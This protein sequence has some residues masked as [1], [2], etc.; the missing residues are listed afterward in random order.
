MTARQALLATLVA[1]AGCAPD[2]TE[3]LLVV[4]SDLA[5]PQELD[6][7]SVE[8]SSD[9]GGAPWSQDYAL[10]PNGPTTLPLSIGLVPESD[11][12]RAFRVVVT[13]LAGGQRRVQR[14]ATL[15]FAPRET[16]ILYLDLLAACLDRL[17]P[18]NRTCL[19][20]GGPCQSDGIST[21]A[22]PRI[23]P[24]RPEDEPLAASPRADGSLVSSQDA[25]AIDTA[26]LPV[27][28]A[29]PMDSGTAD[30]FRV[31][32]P[33]ERDAPAEA[34]AVD[35]SPDILA[36]DAP[37]PDA[38][39]RDS[40]AD[41]P[42]P[43]CTAGT[44]F[45]SGAQLRQC[46]PSG[47]TSTLVTTCGASE[48]CDS[49]SGSCRSQVCAPNQPVCAA[50]RATLCNADGSGHAPGGTDCGVRSCVAGL[51]V[52]VL[53]KED[54]EDGDTMGW[55][56]PPAD[57]YLFSITSGGANGTG[58]GL[59]LTKLK[60]T[61]FCCDGPTR[62]FFPALEPRIVSWW[63]RAGQTERTVGYFG[64]AATSNTADTVAYFNFYGSNMYLTGSPTTPAP[65]VPY[66]ANRWYHI[67]LRD[68]DWQ[69]HTFEYF[70]DGVR[71]AS[72]KMANP[73]RGIARIDLFNGA[74]APD[75][76]PTVSYDEIEF[77]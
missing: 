23:G 55:S 67:E 14:S 40:A 44:R 13:G 20:T 22:L 56:P 35:A 25:G 70:V 21:A 9:A 15:S 10:Q 5:V 16:V 7:V 62:S 71:V 59:L 34:P 57:R 49:A 6:E 65:A 11:E 37:G 42:P 73:V 38:L 60:D 58:R 45:C 4:R 30:A 41:T 3:V 43:V 2:R 64:L 66:V 74:A 24:R 19:P 47:D 18:G 61:G 36:P 48:Y 1:A 26:A 63:I 69:N 28:G 29:T 46:S 8:V 33:A 72:M 12:R 54:F 75:P 53:F 51:C 32:L 39:V 31:D 52:N 76:A 68:I 50:N 27:D 17:C 77:R